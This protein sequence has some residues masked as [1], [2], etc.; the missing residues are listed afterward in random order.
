LSRD[1]VSRL[2]LAIRQVEQRL[3]LRVELKA[4]REMGFGIVAVATLF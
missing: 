2:L 4:A 3:R 1:E